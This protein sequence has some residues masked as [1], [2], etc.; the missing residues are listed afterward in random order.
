MLVKIRFG[1][2]G[3]KAPTRQ[4]VLEKRHTQGKGCSKRGTENKGRRRVKGARPW[5]A[6]SV[7]QGTPVKKAILVKMR[8]KAVLVKRRSVPSR[9]GKMMEAGVRRTCGA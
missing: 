5:G 8:Q 2:E 4:R 1:S 3:E 7:E 6:E 9:E